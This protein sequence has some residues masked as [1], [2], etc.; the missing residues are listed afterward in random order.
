[1]RTR[2]IAL[3]ALVLMASGCKPTPET[4]QA[5]MV[6]PVGTRPSLGLMTTLPLLWGEQASFGDILAN[7]EAPGWVR[8]ALEERFRLEPLDVLDGAALAGVRLLVLAQPRAL[9][10]QENVA[11]DAWVR[12][13]GRV[14]IFAD[15]LLTAHSRFPIGDRR[16]PQDVVLL[17]PLLTHWGLALSFDEDQTEGKREVVVAGQP[18]QIEQAGTLAVTDTAECAISGQGLLARCAIGKGRATIFADA[19]VLAEEDVEDPAARQRAFEALMRT[20]FD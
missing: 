3:A 1:M 7:E 2:F 18:I 9:S 13:G 6:S 11:L 12:G 4:Q 19:H 14:L 17:S 16:R 10:P 20:A 5:A 8:G 15:P